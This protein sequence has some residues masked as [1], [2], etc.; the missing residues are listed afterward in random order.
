MYEHE[1]LCR[2]IDSMVT[3][4]QLNAPA[5]QSMEMVARRLQLIEEAH[6]ISPGSPD[7]SAADHFMGWNSRR[8]GAMVAPALSEHA[9]TNVKNETMVAKELRKAREEAKL[10]RGRGKGGR[11]SGEGADGKTG[12]G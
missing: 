12:Q 3:V 1:V 4:D 7:S 6:R 9:A 11:G 10:G 2:V 8:H 5:L